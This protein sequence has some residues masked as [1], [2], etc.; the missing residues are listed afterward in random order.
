[1][2]VFPLIWLRWVANSC[3]KCCVEVGGFGTKLQ[4]KAST[5]LLFGDK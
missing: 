2:E 1:M 3:M 4:P 5:S